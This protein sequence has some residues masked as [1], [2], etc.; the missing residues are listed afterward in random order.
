MA[1]ALSRS[2][3]AFE[4]VLENPEQYTQGIKMMPETHL[5]GDHASISMA[6]S[7]VPGTVGDVKA[8]VTWVQVPRE[9]GSVKLELV[10]RFE[11][12]MQDN[13][14][15]AMVTAALPHW[16]ISVVDWASD[17]P[18][19]LTTA[20]TRHF[21]PP[22]DIL[23][24]CRI[25]PKVEPRLGKAVADLRKGMSKSGSASMS[26]SIPKKYPASPKGE[27]AQYLV[28]PWGT[29]D[30]EEAAMRRAKAEGT[31]GST[32]PIWYGRFVVP[33]SVDT[34]ASPAG[35]MFL[36]NT[37][38]PYRDGVME[39]AIVIHELMSGGMGEGWGDFIATTVRSTSNYPTTPWAHGHRTVQKASATALILTRPKLIPL[40]TSPSTSL[41]T[42]GV[43]AIGEVWT[44]MMW[45]VSQKLI[46][47]HG[48]SRT[49]LPPVPNEDGS[50]PPNDFYRPQKYD[51]RG[52]PRPLVPQHGNTLF[53][54]LVIE[55]Y[56][57]AA[58][59]AYVLRCSQ[60]N[61]G[62]G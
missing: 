12:E 21:R 6:L 59:F 26:A 57:V 38:F 23:L 45:V 49:L 14:Y 40:L 27:P 31:E 60:C 15:E 54:Q 52:N 16:I 8:R 10:H 39:A 2:H 51:S 55:G 50:M 56:E 29:N 24:H 53:L 47:K 36:W 34:L 33:E 62:G 9:D 25:P 41:G 4:R 28:F 3:P 19:P 18:T 32:H 35:W 61:F 46:E 20:T 17:S 5:P 43:H 1:T 11:V 58:V 22:M 13:W 48:F 42:G 37:A 44:E 30:P 7:G